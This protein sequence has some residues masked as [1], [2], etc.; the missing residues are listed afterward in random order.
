[1]LALHYLWKWN[2]CKYF[3][4]EGTFCYS[5]WSW[6]SNFEFM[7]LV[8][9]CIMDSFS[10]MLSE[11]LYK[12]Q[13]FVVRF[14]LLCKWYVL[15]YVNCSVVQQIVKKYVFYNTSLVLDDESY[16]YWRMTLY[17]LLLRF[18]FVIILLL[19][20]NIF[21][22]EYFWILCGY[23]LPNFTLIDG[24]TENNTRS[25]YYKL[26]NKCFPKTNTQ[27]YWN[28]PLYRMLQIYK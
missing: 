12:C 5:N 20:C 3:T 11:D 16:H 23:W 18:F 14:V 6:Y 7:S 21:L 25:H 1:M 8:R 22:L 9:K 4:V 10:F 15:H 13:K 2:A 27:A 28:S 24:G 26:G 19:N 17:I